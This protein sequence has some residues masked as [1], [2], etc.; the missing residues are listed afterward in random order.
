MKRE[1]VNK[2]GLEIHACLSTKTKVFSSSHINS[3]NIIPNNTVS[4]FDASFPGTLPTLNKEA[5]IQSIKAILALNSKVNKTFSFDRK[6]YFYQDLPLGYQI[7]QQTCPI[8]LEGKFNYTYT[9][10]NHTEGGVGSIIRNDVVTIDRI[11]LEQDSGKSH[12]DL[13]DSYTLVD[14]NR[15]GCGLIEIVFKP[16]LTTSNQAAGVLK[17]VQ[18][19]LRHIGV[20][21]GNMDLGLMRCDVNISVALY[22]KK[23]KNIIFNSPKVEVKNLSSM[24]RVMSAVAYESKRQQDILDKFDDF[25]DLKLNVNKFISQETRGYDASTESTFR[26]RGKEMHVDYRFLPDPDLPRYTVSDQEIAAISESL[27]DIP[28][29]MLMKLCAKYGLTEL[30]VNALI[31]SRGLKKDHGGSH[32]LHFYEAVCKLTHTHTSNVDVYN[33]IMNDVL[34]N[35]KTYNASFSNSPITAIQLADVLMLISQK[36]LKKP[37]A[38]D[39]IATLCAD[40]NLTVNVLDVVALLGF[41]NSTDADAAV[42]DDS[43]IDTRLHDFCIESLNDPVNHYHIKK[44][45]AGKVDG[46]S[47]FFLGDVMRRSKRMYNPQDIKEILAVLLGKL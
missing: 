24:Q 13:H 39:V 3:R 42:S 38:K 28:S 44:Y 34:G 37:Q 46:S 33:W 35:L 11:Q 47:N 2:I 41:N 31:S 29:V 18:D 16:E 26:I 30:Q 8:G 45:K 6:H 21:D 1:W 9:D 23:R 22:D 32:A 10:T 43:T 15:A 20:C 17:S 27:P 40:G 36:K 19:L 7:T 4:L 12:H 25:D 5:V 14:L